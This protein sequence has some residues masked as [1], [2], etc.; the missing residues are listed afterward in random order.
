MLV[1]QNPHIHANVSTKKLM[2][3]VIIALCPAMIVSFLY[4]GLSEIAIM[5]VSVASCVVLE[6]AITKYLLKKPSTAGDL[7]AIVTGI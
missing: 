3:D 2:L 6:W 4:Y 7:S 1:S 5:A